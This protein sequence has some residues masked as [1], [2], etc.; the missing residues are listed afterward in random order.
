[1]GP[2]SQQ[3]RRLSR[4]K[5]RALRVRQARKARETR[6]HLQR[7]YANLPQDARSFFEHFSPVF[8]RPTFLRF[9]ILLVAALLTV[10]RRTVTN[11]LRTVGLLAP[12]EPSSYHRFFSCRRWSLLGL[13]RRLAGWILDRLVP[14]GPVQL[15]A[16]DTVDEHPGDKV[17]GKGCH[18]DAVRSSHNYTAFRWGHKWLVVFVLV[19]VP[20]ATRQWAL[21]IF[22]ILLHSEKEDKK[23]KRRHQTPAQRLLQALLVLRRWFPDRDFVLAADGGFASHELTSGVVRLA[24]KTTYVSRFYAKAA[25]Y[26]PPPVVVLKPNGKRPT[27]GRSR[28]KGAKQDTPEQVVAKTKDRLRLKVSW[29][30][31]EDRQVEVVTATGHW[32]KA[33]QG[34]VLVRWVFVHDLSGTHRD[35]YFYST[36]E[37]QTAKQILETY[38]RRWNVETTFQEMRSYLGL[39]TTRGWT[40]Q[41]VLRAA[42][43]LFGLYSVVVCMY[44]LTPTKYRAK[45]GVRWTGKQAATFSDAISAVRQ[46]LWVE[47]VFASA[48]QQQTFANLPEDFQELL[49]NGLAPAA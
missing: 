27:A 38:T 14:P 40:K 3:R 20:W 39:E 8:R 28:V 24:K 15:A 34:L 9:A 23:H 49:L 19:S 36:N 37:S 35:E 29:Y 22:V 42:P 25:L 5:R 32:Y 4:N 12:G 48:G 1:M 44:L 11:V 21:P 47:W 33:G 10:G 46:W 31:G 18:R 17:Y 30:G 2:S 13:G 16:D 45:G 43:C 6:L 41:T 7:H 26:D